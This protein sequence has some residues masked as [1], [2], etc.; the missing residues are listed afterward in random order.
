MATKIVKTLEFPNSSDGYQINAVAL[1]GKT[2][3]DIRSEMSRVMHFLGTTTTNISDGS[4]TNEITVNSK[5]VTVDNGDVVLYGGY[6]YVWTGSAWEQL[7]QEGSFSLKTHTHTVSHTPAGTV[8]TP[9]ITVTP[10][11]S[12]VNSITAVGSLPS[13]EYTEVTAS[14][15]TSWS[16]GT[17]PSLSDSVS[18]SGPNRVVTLSWSAG[19]APS[20]SYSSVS[21]DNI[22]S[23]SPGTLPT[24][25]SNIDVVTSIKSATSTQPTFTG[26]AA[27]L[28][29]SAADS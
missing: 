26:T 14:N 3:D 22:T 11:T 5:L 8:S 9:T 2:L 20:L 10:N 7:G 6:E 27:T 21:A 29:T 19:T 1:E 4:T 16:A 24:K 25:G 23:W 15:I 17:L 12:T 28:T 18:S 13:L